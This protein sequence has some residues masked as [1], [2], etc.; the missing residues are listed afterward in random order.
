MRSQDSKSHA[1]KCLI[2]STLPTW[3][4]E[5]CKQACCR[6]LEYVKGAEIALICLCVNNPIQ[7]ALPPCLCMHA[8]NAV[9]SQSNM[10]A[11][12]E[13]HTQQGCQFEYWYVSLLGTLL[14][15]G[16]SSRHVTCDASCKLVS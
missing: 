7:H 1:V 8:I 11:E 5:L 10:L 12:H 6:W 16:D 9:I 14:F 3:H 13:R 4:A 2:F 15:C